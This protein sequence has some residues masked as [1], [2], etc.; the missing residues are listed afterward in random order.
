MEEGEIEAYGVS[1]GGERDDKDTSPSPGAAWC[2]SGSSRRFKGKTQG[3][4][5]KQWGIELAMM[6][7]IFQSFRYVRQ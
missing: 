4:G 3:Q 5:R 1:I 2:K 6:K 7:P